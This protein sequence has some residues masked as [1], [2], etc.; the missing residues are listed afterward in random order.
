MNPRSVSVIV[1]AYN[2]GPNLIVAL[3]RIITVLSAAENPL[4]FELLVVDDGSSDETPRALREYSAGK[5]GF[6]RV[7]THD[8][9][10]GLVAAMRTGCEAASKPT[11]V[12]LD[13]DLSYEPSMV[14][15]LL[16][17]KAASGASAA[18]ASPYMEGGQVAH[19]PF[20]RLL[21]SRVANWILSRCSG[22]KLST[23]TGMVRA[24]DTAVLQQLFTEQPVGEF[25]SWAIAALILADRPIVEVP[26]KLEWPPERY[27]AASRL[28]FAS[29]S[30][31]A[32]LVVETASFLAKACRHSKS[33]KTGTLVLTGQPTRP[34]IS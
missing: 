10:Q 6:V 7:I 18:I 14:E 31:R 16:A 2:E 30:R 28:T 34:Y 32:Q 25:N 26:A 24:Y 27:E 23:F 15:K 5:P 9:N 22:G 20:D 12:Y 19:V 11:I 29:L 3:D 21:A 4:D 33:L 8:V 17:A 13:A 1:A